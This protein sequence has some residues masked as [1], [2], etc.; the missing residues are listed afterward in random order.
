MYRHNARDYTDEIEAQVEKH[1]QHS[2]NVGLGE[3]G[4][5][6]HDLRDLQFTYRYVV[7]LDYHCTAILVAILVVWLSTCL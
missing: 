4:E 5:L 3:I 1:L 2:K 6:N 7:G